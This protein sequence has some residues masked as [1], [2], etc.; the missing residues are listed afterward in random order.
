MSKIVNSPSLV[1]G[2]Q[3]STFVCFFHAKCSLTE[4]ASSESAGITV[5][6]SSCRH[7][8][9]FIWQ[10]MQHW[11][12][13]LRNAEIWTI[14]PLNCINLELYHLAE[15]CKCTLARIPAWCS[16]I[17]EKPSLDHVS[18]AYS[19]R[20][21][22]IRDCRQGYNCV[23]LSLFEKFAIMEACDVRLEWLNPNLWQPQTEQYLKAL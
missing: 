6:M 21:H 8:T 2:L 1:S 14:S 20:T 19:K 5:I 23:H 16:L 13:E 22:R 17:C 10:L 4:L 3:Y 15:S 18:S 11:S 7:H 9:E 12:A